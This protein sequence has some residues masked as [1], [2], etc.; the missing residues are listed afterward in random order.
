MGRTG[1]E[2]TPQASLVLG[3]TCALLLATH[4]VATQAT[5]VLKD[6]MFARAAI[7]P[8]TTLSHWWHHAWA[9]FFHR[10]WGHLAFNLAVFAVAF[11]FAIRGLEPW[12][13]LANAYWIGPFTVFTSHILVVLPLA[14]MGL[15]YAIRSLN[16][17]L[18]G[19]S[20]MAYAVVGMALTT[21]PTPIAVAFLVGIV[22]FE[23]VAATFVTGPFI[24]FYHLAGLGLGYWSIVLRRG[25]AS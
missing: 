19:F 2:W 10:S 3:G 25:L 4:I 11:P 13:V 24:W 16:G 22:A 6:G 17:P 18:V 8:A 14:M 9:G 21:T 20:V 12:K 7:T 5:G 23:A 15:P 1:I